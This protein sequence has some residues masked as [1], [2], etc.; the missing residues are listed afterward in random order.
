MGGPFTFQLYPLTL[1]NKRKIA[2]SGYN[3]IGAF[4]TH[5]YYGKTI[6]FVAEYYTLYDTYDLRHITLSS[7]TG[8][9][10]WQILAYHYYRIGKFLK[11]Q[12]K[13]LSEDNCFRW[14]AL[15]SD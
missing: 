2:Y 4:F 8:T 9:A 12:G 3:L 10:G 14:N 7:D 5:I 13:L 6:F 15:L 11:I 1:V